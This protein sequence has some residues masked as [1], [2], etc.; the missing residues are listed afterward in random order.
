MTGATVHGRAWVGRIGALCA[1]ALM[2]FSCSSQDLPTVVTA[3]PASAHSDVGL[4]GMLVEH[5]GC[6]MLKVGPPTPS[7]VLVV[8]PSGTTISMS[9]DEILVTTPQ[10]SAALGDDVLL[11]GG[12]L[13]P[14]G[15]SRVVESDIPPDCL[16]DSIFG[17]G[18]IES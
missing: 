1:A 13:T 14:N 5:Q 7:Y 10:G 8:F 3:R 17:A 15:A 2:S 12:S 11:A 16:V 9:R 6:V 4:E 18:A